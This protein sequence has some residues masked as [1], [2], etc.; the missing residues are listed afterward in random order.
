MMPVWN[1]VNGWDKFIYQFQNI[2]WYMVAKARVVPEMDN[3]LATIDQ[4]K[5]WGYIFGKRIHGVGVF[6][7]RSH[8]I[9]TR[10]SLMES[11]VEGSLRNNF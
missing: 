8:G 7:Y 2:G 3:K 4:A 1:E 11:H 10:K 9:V 5:R 6:F